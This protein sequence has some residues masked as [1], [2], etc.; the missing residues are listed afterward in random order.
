MFLSTDPVTGV[1]TIKL[2]SKVNQIGLYDMKLILTNSDPF[3]LMK[4]IEYEF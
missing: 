2:E 3:I 4:P 1:H